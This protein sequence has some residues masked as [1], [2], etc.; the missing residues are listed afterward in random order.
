M[1]APFLIFRGNILTYSRTFCQP[2]RRKGDRA[3]RSR[4]FSSS[5]P[6]SS[7]CFHR[8]HRMRI[9]IELMSDLQFHYFLLIIKPFCYTALNFHKRH[10]LKGVFS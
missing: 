6:I 2:V 10:Q 3:G 5:L 4:F 1:E 9:A 7:L 8:F